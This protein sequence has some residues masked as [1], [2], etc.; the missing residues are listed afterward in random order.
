MGKKS[1]LI[2][3]FIHLCIGC[4]LLEKFRFC[5]EYSIDLI[6]RLVMG[7]KESRQFQTDIVIL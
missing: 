3:M 7:Q 5:Q 6:S 4:H 2:R 1:M